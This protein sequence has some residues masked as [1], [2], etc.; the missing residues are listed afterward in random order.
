[1]TRARSTTIAIEVGS[2]SYEVGVEPMEETPVLFAFSPREAE[3]PSMW[4]LASRVEALA[5]K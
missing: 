5:L 3:P 2:R 4:V 1:M